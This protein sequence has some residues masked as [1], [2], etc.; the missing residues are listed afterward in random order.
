MP[1]RDG[2]SFGKKKSWNRIIL[3]LHATLG[4]TVNDKQL[5]FR[6]GADSMDSPPPVFTGQKDVTNLGW[7]EADYSITIKQTQPLG[8][9][10]LSITGE[11]NVY[12]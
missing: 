7:S 3:N 1:V 6:T 12:S 4:I 10:L 8:M 2:S 9:T 11:L 5:S